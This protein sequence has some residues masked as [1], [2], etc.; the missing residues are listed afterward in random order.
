MCCLQLWYGG[1]TILQTV[2]SMSPPLVLAGRNDA[3]F[4]GL[5]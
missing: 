5:L 4:K 3:H 1:Q 2:E